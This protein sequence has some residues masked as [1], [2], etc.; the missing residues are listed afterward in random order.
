MCL[1]VYSIGWQSQG[2]HGPQAIVQMVEDVNGNAFVLRSTG[3]RRHKHGSS[4]G[5]DALPIACVV[6][7][8]SGHLCDADCQGVLFAFGIDRLSTEVQWV[9][10]S[11]G[12]AAWTTY[13][14]GIL[15]NVGVHSAAW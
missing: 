4:N 7:F 14:N 5:R 11:T 10:K 1:C 3:G 13:A 8:L 2:R 15:V 9:T 6:H 12:P